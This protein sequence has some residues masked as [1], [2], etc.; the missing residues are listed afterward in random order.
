[1]TLDWPQLQWLRALIGH[2]SIFIRVI[3]R[4]SK[5]SSDARSPEQTAAYLEALEAAQ[6]LSRADR[7]A[8]KD[9]APERH[10]ILA[11]ILRGTIGELTVEFTNG[12]EKVAWPAD[13]LDS[14]SFE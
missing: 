5:I 2:D 13:H 6:N 8:I 12:R 3:G 11:G 1:M 4:E 9:E 10:P 7:D 14:I